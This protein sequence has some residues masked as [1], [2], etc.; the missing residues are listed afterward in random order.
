LWSYCYADSVPLSA[1]AVAALGLRSANW[2]RALAYLTRAARAQAGSV[3][4]A[5]VADPAKS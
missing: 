5:R 2:G 1:T 3:T 4:P